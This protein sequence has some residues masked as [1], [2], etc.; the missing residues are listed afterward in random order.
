[1]TTTPKGAAAELVTVRLTLATEQW[2][3][4]IHGLQGTRLTVISR[5]QASAEPPT[6]T[7]ATLLLNTHGVLV[8]EGAVWICRAP[9]VWETRAH[10]I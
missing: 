9:G 6:D 1:L 5:E 2:D 3:V 10:R 8:A 7:A 4:E